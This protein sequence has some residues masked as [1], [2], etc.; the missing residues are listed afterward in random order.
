MH[1]ITKDL[2]CWYEV[3]HRVLPW[4]NTHDPYAIW[5]SEVMLQQTRV[6]T[7]IPYFNRFLQAF[8]NIQALAEAEEEAYLKYWEG[9]GY[10]SRVRNLVKGARYVVEHFNGVLPE[11]EASLLSVP[12]IGPYTAKAILSIAY[13]EPY[14]AVDGN[15]IRVYA[16]LE[17]QAVIPNEEKAKKV[18]DAF[19]SGILEDADP[20]LFNQALMDLGELVCIPNGAPL[21]HNCPLQGYCKAHQAG[22]EQNYPLPKIK[23]Q[24]KEE[25]RLVLLLIHQGKLILHK[26]PSTGL[27]AGMY[28]LPN[29]LLDS[30]KGVKKA[31]Q[32][33]QISSKNP[34]FLGKRTHIFTHLKW[35]MQAYVAYIDEIPEGMV[36]ASLTDIQHRYTIPNAFSPFINALLEDGYALKH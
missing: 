32:N 14:I 17:Q 29:V 33:L 31:M 16:R 21:C 27:L 12:G 22:K 30:P 10:Y 7:V 25:H 5:V 28:E 23:P 18:C 34:V 36:E 11:N 1:P 13:G 26:R 24:K 2:L 6:D 35:H 3:A 8:P 4:R 19:L 15:L 20:G 9:L